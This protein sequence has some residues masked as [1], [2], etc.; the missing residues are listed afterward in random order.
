MTFQ[1]IAQIPD[2]QITV[3]PLVEDAFYLKKALA[4]ELSVTAGTK[5]VERMQ[6]DGYSQEEIY[7]AL[8]MADRMLANIK[9]Y[10]VACAAWV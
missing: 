2:L 1:E 6:R 5:A 9:K 8:Q 10:G 4:D 7:N 3:T